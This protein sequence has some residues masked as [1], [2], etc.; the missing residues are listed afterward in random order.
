M[1]R[2]DNIAI[3]NDTLQILSQG[4]YE[5]NS[6]RIILKL[7]QQEMEDIQVLLPQEVYAI[8]QSTSFKPAK[9]TNNCK[10]TC[11]N[12]DSYS[13]A[14]KYA[15][16]EEKP[17]VLNFAN[18]VHPGGGVRN[19]ARAQEEDL[20]R[21][22]SLLLSLESDA[23]K[24]YYHYNYSL[25]SFLASDALMIT[26][27]VEIIKDVNAQLLDDTTIVPVI[28][29]AAPNIARGLEGKSEDQYQAMFYTRIETLLKCAAY[30]GYRKLILGAWGCGA[31]YNDAATVA[32]LFDQALKSLDY[33]GYHTDDLFTNIDFAVLDRTH[34]CYNFNMFQHY[35][36]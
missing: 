14:L 5:K 31:F 18:A 33:N 17:L 6:N 23:A 21:K 22:S 30:F 13:Q 20:C 7:S 15:K 32:R 19:G 3:L 25:H 35:F 12:I 2:T 16:E 1:P 29:S 24:K 8:S 9:I 27:K 28:T 34:A 11:E 4:Y 36:H 26:P 10:I